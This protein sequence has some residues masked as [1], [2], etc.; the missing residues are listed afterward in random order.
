MLHSGDRHTGKAIHLAAQG[1]ATQRPK[2][3]CEVPAVE[4]GFCVCPAD[5]SHLP[6][7]Q[8]L[9]RHYHRPQ[10]HVSRQDPLS[11]KEWGSLRR[12]FCNVQKTTRKQKDQEDIRIGRMHK[13]QR[14]HSGMEGGSEWY[15]C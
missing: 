15:G 9:L 3:L 8:A 5:L 12:H 1:W 13:G 2:C 14:P 11:S 10:D 4:H 6:K 7:R